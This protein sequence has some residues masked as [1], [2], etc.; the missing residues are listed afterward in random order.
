MEFIKPLNEIF[1]QDNTFYTSLTIYSK[2]I[3]NGILASP[4]C[5]EIFKLL[6]IYI[7]N[8][9]K[10]F[11]ELDYLAFCS[12]IYIIISHYIGQ[13]PKKPGNYLTYIGSNNNIILFQEVCDCSLHSDLKPDRY[14][15]CSKIYD[16]NNNIIF[17]N[18]YYDY[19][20]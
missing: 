10:N 7:I 3:Y 18:R 5:N 6:I 1:I 20:W 9:N 13:Q 14:G 11:L 19:P 12:Q 16:S 8:I 4:P 17:N 2:S 15:F